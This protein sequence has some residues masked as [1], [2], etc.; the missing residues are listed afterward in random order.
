MSVFRLVVIIRCSPF[1]FQQ[2]LLYTLAPPSPLWNCFS[3]DLSE[4]LSLGLYQVRF[5]PS[6]VNPDLRLLSRL[7]LRILLMFPTTTTTTLWQV[8]ISTLFWT[9]AQV[10]NVYATRLHF[11]LTSITFCVVY[12]S[13]M[14]LYPWIKGP[15]KRPPQQVVL[16]F[17]QHSPSAHLWFQDER[18][19]A[20]V[21][22]QPR[23]LLSLSALRPQSLAPS[24]KE[25][26]SKCRN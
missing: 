1:F 21:S 20:P 8:L 11:L 5:P 25:L 6:S 9:R 13:R 17:F 24:S 16:G 12:L 19:Q 2:A 22:S 23:T 7:I 14:W 26:K 10:S 15:M 3:S 18:H 4:K